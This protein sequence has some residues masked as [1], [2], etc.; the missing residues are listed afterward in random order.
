MGYRV[1][2]LTDHSRHT[3]HNSLYSLCRS[4]LADDRVTSLLVASRGFDRNAPFF[5]NMSST[6]VMAAPIG[7]DFKYRDDDVLFK[8]DWK[9]VEID[10]FDL[11]LCRFPFPIKPGFLEYLAEC[12]DE[13]KIINRPSGI[14]ETSNKAFLF[15]FTSFCPPMQLCRS[16]EDILAFARIFPIVLKPLMSYGGQGVVKVENG[17]VNPGKEA[18]PLEQYIRNSDIEFPILAMKFLKR[19]TEGDKR[20]VV[21][22]KKIITTTL[23]YPPEGSWLCNVAQGG[24]AELTEPTDWEVRMVREISPVL[25]KKGIAVYGMDTLLND[26]GKRVLS[27]LNTLSIG[28]IYPSEKQSKIP[29]SKMVSEGIL[30]YFAGL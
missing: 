4:M 22:N 14:L 2:C 28:G 6:K 1:L 5:S 16:I 13:K 15:N 20:I 7:S 3:E 29:F 24:R 8:R 12:T 10:D 26:D 17:L 30:N 23:R 27:E 9:E 19:V 25:L 18:L 11:I 21:A